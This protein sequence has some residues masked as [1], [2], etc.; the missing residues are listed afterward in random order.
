MKRRRFFMNGLGCIMHKPEGA[1]MKSVFTRIGAP[2]CVALAALLAAST[3]PMMSAQTAGPWKSLFN[4]KDFTGWTVL[5]GAGGGARGGGRA[6][7]GGAAPAPAPATPP[8]PP[9]TNPEDRGWKIENGVIISVTP[10][11]GQ[12]GGSLA[13]IDKFKDVELELE[14]MLAEAGTR[15][16]PKLGEKQ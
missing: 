7:G 4:G 3:S 14:F 16:T 9:S 15:C 13:T 12:R 6:G 5:A 1:N 11:A 2:A 10:V 8:A